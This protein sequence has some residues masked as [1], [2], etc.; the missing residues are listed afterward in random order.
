MPHTTSAPVGIFGGTFDPVHMGHLRTGWELLTGLGLSELRFVP[1][2][3]PPHRPPADASDELR[4]QMLA[5]AIAGQPGFRVDDRELSRPG[6]SYT[7]DTLE[8]LRAEGFTG[9][10]CLVLGMDAFL[11][12]P[13]WHR[14]REIPRLAHLVVVR[15]PGVAQA[16][17]GEI[18]ALL[19]ERGTDSPAELRRTPGGR[20]LVRDVTQLGVASSGIR[21]LIAGGGDPRYLVPDSV[22]ELI[23][24]HQ[25]Y[26][27]PKEVP[28]R[29]K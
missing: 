5:A 21:A 24:H 15:R 1:C 26:V 19:A 6:P 28:L 22:R 18:G 8:S 4:R 23:L 10:L 3:L 11:G 14:W 27:T 17:G 2:R 25:L 7:V 12:L 13:T 29:A 16:N 20:V 9:P